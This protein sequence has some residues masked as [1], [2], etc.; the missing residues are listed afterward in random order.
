MRVLL[1]TLNSKFIHSNLA[2]RYLQEACPAEET[3]LEEYTINDRLEVIAGEIYKSCADVI[4]F[5]CYIWNI[6]Q[7]LELVGILRQV[8]PRT[9]IILGGPEVS[10]DPAAYLAPS[11]GVDYVVFGE[12]EETFRELIALLETGP[13][14]NLKQWRDA[15]GL[16]EIKGLAFS[17]AAAPT[18]NAARELIKDLAQIASPYITTAGLEHKIAYVESSRGCPFNCQYCLSSTL[19]GVRFLPWERT[20]AELQKLVAAGVKQIK[21]VDRT[22]NCNQGHA[23]KVMRYLAEWHPAVNFHFEIS[24]DLLDETMLEFLQQVPSGLF[25]FEVGV[26]STNLTSLD[27][28]SRRTDLAKLAANVKAVRA[29]GRVRQF[30][31]LI[32]GLPGEDYRSFAN[33]FNE[34]FSWQPDKIQ[35][36]FLKLLKGSGMRSKAAD[37]DYRFA[38]APPYQVLQNS[39]LSYAELLRLQGI[40]DMVDKFFNSGRFKHTL[41]YLINM[42]GGDAFALFEAL[43]TYWEENGY[44]R[45]AQN[46]R[47]LYELLAEFFRERMRLEET[48][49][50][51]L[52][53]LDYLLWEKPTQVPTWFNSPSIP[54]FR[55]RVETFFREGLL[56]LMPQLKPLSR[57][58]LHRYFHLEPFSPCLAAYLNLPLLSEEEPL[59]LLFYYPGA[60]IKAERPGYI[61]VAL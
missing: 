57:R 26:Q 51:E 1:T 4:G 22:F 61:P 11:M 54:C 48:E 5:S 52:L 41:A 20:K 38:A 56:Q 39:W 23:L 2:L 31:D 37:W 14:Q 49:F 17:T 28:I 55:E 6:T 35:L 46:A 47:K 25:Q 42:F 44:H 3:L 7:T 60:L 33:S 24:A 40:E 32:A 27:L 45:Q 59:Y 16:A 53:K 36:G 29:G 43:G 58:E 15:A 8:A 18:V 34:V 21:F 12:G 9:V 19:A 50:T 30:L 13:R 10:Y